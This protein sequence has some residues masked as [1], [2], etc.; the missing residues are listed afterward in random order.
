MIHCCTILSGDLQVLSN[1]YFKLGLIFILETIATKTCTFS[2]QD[3]IQLELHHRFSLPMIAK[4]K[5]STNR[6]GRRRGGLGWKCPPH[7]LRIDLL[8]RLNSTKKN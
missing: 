3:E 2:G 4:A 5:F 8:I 6:K 7:F 1:F